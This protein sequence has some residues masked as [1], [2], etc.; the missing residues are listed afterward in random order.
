MDRVILVVDKDW[1]VCESLKSTAELARKEYWTDV[2]LIFAKW[3][4]RFTWNIPEVDVCQKCGIEIRD[5]LG[6]KTYN[7]SDYRNK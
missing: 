2:K 3:W 4:D 1:S 5:G 6:M 7:S